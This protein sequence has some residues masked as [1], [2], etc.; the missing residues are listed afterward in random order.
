MVKKNH[1][2]WP[3]F[4]ALKRTIDDFNDMCPLLELMANKAM[5]QR[6]WHRIMEITSY[7][8]DLESE[9][10]CLKNILEAPL[11]KYKEDIEVSIRMC[12]SFTMFIIQRYLPKMVVLNFRIFAYQP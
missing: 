9:G 1:Q 3:A 7:N 6:H 10:F 4:H 12:I 11:L 8:F 5:K 2:E